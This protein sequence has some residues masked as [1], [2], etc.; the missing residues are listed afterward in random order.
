MV[1]RDA[2]RRVANRLHTLQQTRE[3]ESLLSWEVQPETRLESI[4]PENT[5]DTLTPGEPPA[6]PHLALGAGFSEHR[7]VWSAE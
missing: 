5:S 6:P 3:G 4:T 1:E 7:D 2:G